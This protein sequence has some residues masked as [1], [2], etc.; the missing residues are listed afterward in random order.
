MV[1]VLHAEIG[2]MFN[3]MHCVHF[4]CRMNGANTLE[5][6]NDRPPD[7][8]PIC[9]RKLQAAV[10]FDCAERYRALAD[11]ARGFCEELGDGRF[12]RERP[13][14]E[15]RVREVAPARAAALLGERAVAA[16]ATRGRAPSSAR[17]GR[18]PGAARGRWRRCRRNQAAAS[19]AT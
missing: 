12:A 4:H 18:R 14:F 10:R 1:E 15:A 7:I 6:G 17:Q 3:F 5:E 8:C 19:L 2:H 9:L 13:W 11:T 16:A